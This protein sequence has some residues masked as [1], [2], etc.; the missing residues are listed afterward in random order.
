MEKFHA[1]PL[2]PATALTIALAGCSSTKPAAPVP[3][4]KEITNPKVTKQA[5]GKTADGQS[6]DQVAVGE[7]A[8]VP[9]V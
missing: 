2:Y 8:G 3:E 7:S 6:V 9:R 4:A 1:P 5:Y